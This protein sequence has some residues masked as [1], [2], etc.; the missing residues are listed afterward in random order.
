M[1]FFGTTGLN[2]YKSHFPVEEFMPK[3]L[4]FTGCTSRHI[5]RNCRIIIFK[6]QKL[7]SS[8]NE[9]V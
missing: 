4:N 6:L 3:I 5:V 1:R 8:K 2:F 7:F 9:E